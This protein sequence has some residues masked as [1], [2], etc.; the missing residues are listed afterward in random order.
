M[1]NRKTAKYGEIALHLCC[2]YFSKKEIAVCQTH[3]FNDFNDLYGE[4]NRNRFYN[5]GYFSKK[6]ENGQN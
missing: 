5:S 6:F 3:D 2:T 1:I 4:F